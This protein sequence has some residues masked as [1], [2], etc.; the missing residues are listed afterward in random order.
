MKKKIQM[1]TAYTILFSIIAVVAM[2]TWVIPAGEYDYVDGTTQ[3]IPGTY[4]VVESN[5]QAL[6][7]V[8]NAPINGFYEAK[9]IALF[10]LVI[11]GF[12]GVVMKTGAID[13]GI[14]KVIARLKGREKIMIPILMSIF[15][16]GGTSF[17]MA[18]ETIAFYPL[19]IPVFLGAGYDV[20]TAV[21]VILLGA[22][23]GV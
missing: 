8:I 13:A 4:K 12:L 9:D 11:G 6:W 14:E 22:G 7:E 23:T 10:V 15:A 5:P 18:E 21:A 20:I 3:P 16:A 1:P 19:L 2:L 17:G